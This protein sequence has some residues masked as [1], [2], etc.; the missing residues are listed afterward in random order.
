VTLGPRSELV[1]A[2]LLGPSALLVI[3]TFFFIAGF[4][5]PQSVA[6][7]GPRRFVTDRIVR[8]G[9]PYL[10]FAALLW[11]LLVWL[12]YRAAG[13]AVSYRWV[14]ADREPLLDAGAL[15]F[16]AVLLIFSLVYAGLV[17]AGLVGHRPMGGSGA[18]S[19]GTRMVR[20]VHLV[21]LAAVVAMA[22]F[23]VRV[24]L[25]ARGNQPGDLHIWQWPQ[26]AAMFGLGIAQAHSGLA[27]RVPDQLRRAG[28]YIV[29]VTVGLLPML[30]IVVGMSN[31]G[32]DVGPYLGGWSWQ[33]LFTA[34]VEGILVV[35]GSVWLLG[36]A[37]RRLTGRG[38]LATASA[39]GAYAAFILQGPVLLALA[40][41]VRP[42]AAPAEVKA[43]LVAAAAIVG[44][45]WLGWLLVTRTAFGRFL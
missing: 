32:R 1:L 24:W 19:G 44:S 9:V 11:P 35:A 20:G 36:A 34:T 16:V 6:R 5:V 26:C 25:P 8:L 22:T 31:L 2:A 23:V 12:C 4:F 38:R 14:V 42:L 33:A 39:R 17:G 41:M 15:W 43:F 10:V 28:G 13:R 45:F 40:L 37:Q 30:A 3:G 18:G 29:L 21:T 7:R 27:Q